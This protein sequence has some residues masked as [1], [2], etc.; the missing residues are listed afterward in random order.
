MI[1]DGYFDSESTP[2]MSEYNWN[3]WQP[4]IDFIGI[5]DIEKRKWLTK[6]LQLIEDNEHSLL[7][8]Q[9]G[10]PGPGM[11]NS[12]EPPKKSSSDAKLDILE[13]VIRMTNSSKIKNTNIEFSNDNNLETSKVTITI[14]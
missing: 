7:N 3:K 11:C 1:Y 13:S 4:V 2:E 9:D 10:R 8:S 12:I 14:E 5:T 6:Y